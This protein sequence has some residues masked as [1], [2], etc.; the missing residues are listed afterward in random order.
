[1]AVPG[2]ARCVRGSAD[3]RRTPLCSPGCPFP[4]DSNVRFTYTAER[5]TRISIFTPDTSSGYE[6]SG[7]GDATQRTRSKTFLRR[8]TQHAACSSPPYGHSRAVTIESQVENR[9]LQ[10]CSFRTLIRQDRHPGGIGADDVYSPPDEEGRLWRTGRMVRSAVAKPATDVSSHALANYAKWM[11]PT[12]LETSS[13]HIRLN[14][15]RGRCGQ[16]WLPSTNRE[17]T[18]LDCLVTETRSDR[19]LGAQAF[20]SP[21]IC[22]KFIELGPLFGGENGIELRERFGLNG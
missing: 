17:P 8:W 10:L 3:L 21:S 19:Q 16:R 7:L 11:N 2:L 6:V 15:G 13:V 22:M 18:V 14:R 20:H 1:M 12:T 9:D 5:R 4:P